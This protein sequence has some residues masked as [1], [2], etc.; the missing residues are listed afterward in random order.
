MMAPQPLYGDKKS[1]SRAKVFEALQRRRA[2][3]LGFVL[4]KSRKR[5]P[6]IHT[7]FGYKIA[8]ELRTQVIIGKNYELTIDQVATFLDMEEYDETN[9]L[10]HRR[11]SDG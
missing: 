7:A 2:K 4:I 6:N 3:R 5:L 11:T 1:K 10:I 9:T 8:D